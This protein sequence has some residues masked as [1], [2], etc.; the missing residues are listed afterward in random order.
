MIAHCTPCG[1]ITEAAGPHNHPTL[2]AA[3]SLENAPLPTQSRRACST[4]MQVQGGKR[5]PMTHGTVMLI[6]C[7]QG[8]PR[9]KL[10]LHIV[11]LKGN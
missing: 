3:Q 1:T 8:F 6:E 4:T 9:T 11:A 5:D 2:V 10:Q 7:V